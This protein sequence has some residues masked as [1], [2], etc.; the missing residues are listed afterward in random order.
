MS[1]SGD[2][3]A[4]PEEVVFRAVKHRFERERAFREA[5]RHRRRE[6]LGGSEAP[7]EEVNFR[8]VKHH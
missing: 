4:P 6:F 2:G 1:F 7:P 8:V 3:E 5:V